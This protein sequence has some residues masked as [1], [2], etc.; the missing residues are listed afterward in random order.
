MLIPRL[1]TD[2]YKHTALMR[3]VCSFK[4]LQH[5]FQKA[6]VF[7]KFLYH[8]Q[9][10]TPLMLALL[11]GNDECAAALI[12]A[13]AK[14]NLENSR[15]LTAVDLIQRRSGPKF[16]LEACEGRVEACRRVSLLAR[17]WVEMQF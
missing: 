16:L 3:A 14:L 17:G 5:R 7:S 1:V 9:G 8:V 15:G 2:W 13:G 6:T 10:A 12:A 11:S 4:V